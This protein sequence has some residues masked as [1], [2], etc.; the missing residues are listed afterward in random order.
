M[1]SRNFSGARATSSSEMSCSMPGGVT[2]TEASFSAL[3]VSLAITRGS[4]GKSSECEKDRNTANRHKNWPWET[5]F[6]TCQIDE[7]NNYVA[8][9]YLNY[10]VAKF[11][12]FPFGF[13]SKTGV[14]TPFVG[15]LT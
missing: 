3:S 14:W 8:G 1:S 10:S 2:L 13:L 9:D 5:A 4:V 15:D 11:H 12:R 7:P 6:I